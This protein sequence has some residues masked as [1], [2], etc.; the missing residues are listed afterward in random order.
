MPETVDFNDPA[1]HDRLARFVWN[2]NPACDHD[3]DAWCV[4]AYCP[5]RMDRIADRVAKEAFHRGERLTIDRW[6]VRKAIDTPPEDR[7][8]LQ[9]RLF[10]EWDGR[11]DGE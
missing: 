8:D 4:L 10:R 6:H 3:E 7:D 1:V 9:R 5:V 2:P 11:E